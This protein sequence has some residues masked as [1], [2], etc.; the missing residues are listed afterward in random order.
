MY[1]DDVNTPKVVVIGVVLAVLVFVLIVAVQ[2]LYRD[3]TRAESDRQYQPPEQLREGADREVAE[4]L[5][6]GQ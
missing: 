6:E 4:F 2:V 1:A 5:N 3:F